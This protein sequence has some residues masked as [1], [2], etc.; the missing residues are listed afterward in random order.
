[1]KECNWAGWVEE[2]VEIE[3]RRYKQRVPRAVCLEDLRLEDEMRN[4]LKRESKFR[5]QKVPLL[6]VP[7]SPI[8]FDSEV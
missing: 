2:R 4:I 8:W 5:E 7:H 3:N 6:R 1:M